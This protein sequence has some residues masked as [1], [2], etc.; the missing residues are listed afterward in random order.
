MT[1]MPTT[2]TS[3]IIRIVGAQ[4]AAA[5]ARDWCGFVL[6]R[7][8]LDQLREERATA[9]C[10]ELDIARRP[11]FLCTRIALDAFNAHDASEPPE[12]ELPEWWKRYD[13]L[14]LRV[15]ECFALDTADRNRPE[16]AVDASLDFI[17]AAVR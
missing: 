1:A 14:L 4:D 11:T 13:A 7:A 12:G 8:L 10:R 6:Y 2:I 17:R 15:G 9:A 3:E 16:T 5:R